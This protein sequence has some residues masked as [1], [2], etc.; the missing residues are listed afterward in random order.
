MLVGPFYRQGWA[1][2][3]VQTSNI[4]ATTIVVLWVK[5]PKNCILS[6]QSSLMHLPIC[7]IPFSVSLIQTIVRSSE[8]TCKSI[9]SQSTESTLGYVSTCRHL[10]L[11]KLT[12]PE[13]QLSCLSF[14]F[15][16]TTDWMV[17]TDTVIYRSAYKVVTLFGKQML[18]KG[19][20]MS[21]SSNYT[22]RNA[23]MLVGWEDE[24]STENHLL[25]DADRN[26]CWGCLYAQSPR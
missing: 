18:F 16:S 9:T 4:V 14:T 1:S 6:A 3:V 5:Q 12:R 17:A 13:K 22:R 11:P 10:P 7:I 26:K 8:K 24:S 20:L 23:C 21:L 2:I 19:K 15:L 25:S